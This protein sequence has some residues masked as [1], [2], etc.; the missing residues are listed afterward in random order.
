FGDEY[1]GTTGELHVTQKRWL[2]PHWQRFIG[3][4]E[5]IGIDRNSD[6]NGAS[7]D[8]ASLFQTTTTGGRRW[9][10]ADAFLRP[11]LKR[12]SLELVSKALV[13]RVLISDRRA[14]G[15]EYEHAGKRETAHAEREIVLC[16]G[17]YG[18]PQVLMLSGIG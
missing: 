5:A 12:D 2:S 8:G 3:A 16:A 4:A 9:S 18:S 14:V 10:G 11:A 6:Y 1:H 7:Q 13:H 17:A 15:I